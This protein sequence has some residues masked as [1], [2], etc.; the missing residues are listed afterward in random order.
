MPDITVSHLSHTYHLP[1]GTV[2]QALSDLNAHFP[3]G[4]FSVVVGPSGCGKTTLLRLLA[5]LETATG[6]Q[7]DFGGPRPR[8]GVMF[9]APRL[10]PWLTVEENVRIWQYGMGGSTALAAQYLHLFG[11]DSFRK[12]YPDQLSGGMAQRVA[13]VRTLACQPQ[14]LLLDE[15]FAALD[16]F[17]REKLQDEL[18][19]Q[20]VR[21]P[22]TI[23]F[24]THDLDEAL[25]LGERILVLRR[26]RQSGLLTRSEPYPR[27]ALADRTREKQTILQLLEEP[28]ET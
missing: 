10:L 1:D 25:R 2:V 28:H 20:Y 27:Q 26:G 6:G 24:I 12:A 23:I 8:T 19:E 4:S 22:L 15:P 21:Q 9:Q 3:A 7:I 5:G 18:T 13:L 17:T 16:Y 14:L 11:L